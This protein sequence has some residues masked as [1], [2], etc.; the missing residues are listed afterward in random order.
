M[1]IQVSHSRSWHSV[2][3][4]L[5]ICFC[6]PWVVDVQGQEASA[7]HVENACAEFL[8]GGNSFSGWQ[9]SDCVS[10]WTSWLSVLPRYVYGPFRERQLLVEVA[11]ELRQRGMP[12]LVQSGAYNDG[13]GSSAI[14][15]V[16]AWM[17]AEEIGCDWVTP[18]WRKTSVDGQGTAMYCHSFY[19]TADLTQIR[20]GNAVRDPNKVRCMLHNWVAYFGF[21]SHSVTLP[22]NRTLKI[23]EVRQK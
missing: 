8:D 14:R 18:N 11:Q 2:S 21:R 16:A 20:L 1:P 6:C 9:Y 4:L 3:W 19:T 13:V 5:I 7:L 22:T 15:H 23:V 17:F 12:C 10:V